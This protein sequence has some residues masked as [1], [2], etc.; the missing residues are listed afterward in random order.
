[1]GVDLADIQLKSKYNKGIKYLLC[2]IDLVSKYVW[3]VTLKD[4]KG[5]TIVDEFQKVL[6]S[7]KRKPNKIWVV[8][9]SEFYNDS[10]KRF[11]KE[12]HIEMY[13][14]FNERKSVVAERFIR[15][16]T[17]KMFK[18]MTSVSKNVYFDALVDFVD[19]YHNT[20]NRIIKTKPDDFKSN[21]YV[22]HN[23]DYNE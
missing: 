15:T 19:K 2:A 5:V 20:F 4:E 21:S 17:N 12:N 8:K 23:A 22:K 6:S 11:L 13:S 1:M 18:H 14:A 9:G 16:L 10:C 3:V 7:S